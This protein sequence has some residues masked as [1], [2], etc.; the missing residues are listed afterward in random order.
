MKHLTTPV[1]IAVLGTLAASLH[2]KEPV[3]RTPGTATW[4][5]EA[6]STGTRTV[7]TLTKNTVFDWEQLNLKS[8]SEL[9]FDFKEGK[10]VVNFLGGTETHMIDGAV[11]SNGIVAFFSPTAG[12]EINGSIIAKGVTLATLN[13]DADEFSSGNG[14]K[15]SGPAGY[16]SLTINGRVEATDGDVVLG[17]ESVFVSDTGRIK[18]SQDV[19][20]GGGIEVSVAASGDRRVK[21][22]S[23]MGY[24]LH[25]GETSGSRIEVAAST[26]VS[27]GGT[28]TAGNGR[29]FLQVGESGSIT[30]E[31]SGVIVGDAVFE[32]EFDPDGDVLI[33]DEGDIAPPVGDS[34]LTLPKL[35]RPDGTKVSSEPQTF[36]VT[37]PMSASSD[38]G[39]D[40]N[41]GSGVSVASV[42]SVDGGVSVDNPTSGAGTTRGGSSVT[43]QSTRVG[44]TQLISTSRTATYNLP[45]NASNAAGRDSSYSER[46]EKRMAQRGAAKSMLQRSSFFGMRGGNT[47]LAKR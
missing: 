21:A 8:G 31:S 43:P 3:L 12:L 5:T 45:V 17:G 37:T 28:F 16:N 22:K 38:A 20:I 33:P 44:G 29:I 19:L 42:A 23:G 11:T 40:S 25:M 32:G 36:N 46:A 6:T 41:V 7:F 39:R 18:A 14:Y 2:A 47:A 9:V 30:N 1:C 4:T 13:A 27:N 34:T 26:G 35:S 10:T 15:M 24:V